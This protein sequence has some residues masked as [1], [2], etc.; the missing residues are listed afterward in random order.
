[1]IKFHVRK[2]KPFIYILSNF[3]EFLSTPRLSAAAVIDR[4]QRHVLKKHR[5]SYRRAIFKIVVLI[6]FSM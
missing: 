4:G 6:Y 3:H 2:V 5:I 1:M